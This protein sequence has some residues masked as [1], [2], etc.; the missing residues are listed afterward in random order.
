[1]MPGLVKGW[2]SAGPG[3]VRSTTGQIYTTTLGALVLDITVE[4]HLQNFKLAND[5]IMYYCLDC[6]CLDYASIMSTVFKMICSDDQL[7]RDNLSVC[8]VMLITIR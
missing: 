8:R 1:M 4:D 2:S 3:E 7:S 5:S 6:Q